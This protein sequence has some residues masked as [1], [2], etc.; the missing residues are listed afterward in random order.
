MTAD[1][2]TDQPELSGRQVLVTGG[3]GFIGSHLTEALVERNDVRVVDDLSA[4][5]SERVHPEATFVEGDVRDRETIDSAMTDVDVVFHEAGLVSVAASTERPVDSQTAN[6]GGTLNVLDAARRADARAVVASS[7]AVYG[8][9]DTVPVSE[10]ASL[11][12]TSPY[13]VDKLAVDHYTRLFADLYGLPTV[14]LRYFNV[15]G[16][17]QPAEGY[18]GVISTFL[19]QATAGEPLTIHGDGAQTR[20]FVHVEDVVRANLR[21]AVTSNV[22]RAFNVGTGEATSI[23]TLARTIK[24]VTGTDSETIRVDGREGDIRES[25]ADLT[26]ARNCLGYEPRV[27]LSD[28]LATILDG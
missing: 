22:G 21:A 16:P 5:S 3:A 7:A 25:V 26:A 14:A 27:A 23:E 28:G 15:Y 17:G 2:A 9:P 19:E 18:S 13:G 12:P 24:R 6:V 8:H 10:D 1:A 4:G 11:S 20:D